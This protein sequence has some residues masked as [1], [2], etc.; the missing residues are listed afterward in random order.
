MNNTQEETISPFILVKNGK[1]KGMSGYVRRFKDRDTVIVSIDYQ[2]PNVEI[3]YDDI[4]QIGEKAYSIL[5][6]SI[7]KDKNGIL[8]HTEIDIYSYITEL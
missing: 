7:H 8:Q 1:Y 4:I 5:R 2:N 3:K 6:L